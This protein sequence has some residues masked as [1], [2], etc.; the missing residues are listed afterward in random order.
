MCY[1]VLSNKNSLKTYYL[2]RN[3]IKEEVKPGVTVGMLSIM[4]IISVMH[5][6]TLDL[7]K[8]L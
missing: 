1:R 5:Y 4:W 2:V 3:V 7:H 6:L 8:I